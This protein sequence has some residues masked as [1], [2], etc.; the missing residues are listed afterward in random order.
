VNDDGTNMGEEVVMAY[1]KGL[2]QTAVSILSY[3]AI[4]TR[5]RLCNG[6]GL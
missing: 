5:Y 4:E 1:F 6:V 2:L 3:L